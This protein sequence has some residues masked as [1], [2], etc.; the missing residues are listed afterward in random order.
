[1]QLRGDPDAEAFGEWLLQVGHGQ[2]SNENEEF[3]IPQEMQSPNV[4][5]LKNFIYPDIESSPP[6]LPLEYFLSQIILAPQNFD[7][8][9]MNKIL[10][11]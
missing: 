4:E 3:E 5:C 9:N 10:L 8:N 11:D 6:P 7:V 2:N 1:M